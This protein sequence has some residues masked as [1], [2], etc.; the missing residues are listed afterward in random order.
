MGVRL[1]Q[2]NLYKPIFRKQKI[3]LSFNEM[4]LILSV[5]AVAM[6]GI[7]GYMYWQLNKLEQQVNLSKQ[8]ALNLQTSINQLQEQ[9]RTPR[10]NHMLEIEL[11][12]VKKSQSTTMALFNT[13][14]T[15][16]SGNQTGFSGY[17]EGLAHQTQP[18]LWFTNITIAQSGEALSLQGRTQS[19]EWVP[20]LLKRLKDEKAFD[21]TTFQ[22]MELTRTD[23]MN[24][25]L[26][27]NLMSRAAEEKVN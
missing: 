16:V 5:A 18:G 12:R 1:Q 13:L 27:F 19:P 14:K 24:S 20:Q 2:I 17:F 25:L 23:E 22:I 6:T 15:Q 7:S 8:Q 26:D 4:L 9:L 3:V 11:Q 21:N 10:V